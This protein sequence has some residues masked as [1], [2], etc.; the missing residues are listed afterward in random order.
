MGIMQSLR[1]KGRRVD[2]VGAPEKAVVEAT[3]L[4][5]L[6]PDAQGIATYQLHKFPS[7]RDAEIFVDVTLRGRA[8]EGAVLF[9]ALN[10]Q[11]ADHSAEPLV[12][13][14]D[15]DLP[16][17]Y[18][19]SFASIDSCHDFIRHEMTRGLQ[20]HQ[21][22]VYWAVPARVEAD[23]WGRAAVTPS[24]A[25]QPAFAT[26]SAMVTGTA[27]ARPGSEPEMLGSILPFTARKTGVRP[28]D[29]RYLTEADL[30]ETIREMEEFASTFE[31]ERAPVIDFPSASTHIRRAQ[32]SVAMI[33]AWGTFALALDEALDVYVAQQV[34]IR[35]ALNRIMRALVEAALAASL[36]EPASVN[37]HGSGV[38]RGWVNASIALAH[39][40]TVAIRRKL[41][42]RVWMNT[43]WTLEEAAYAHRLETRA[44]AIRGWR[45]ASMACGEAAT[46]SIVRDAALAEEG[47]LPDDTQIAEWL[48]K[49]GV[50]RSTDGERATKNKRA[51][52]WEPRTEPFEGFHSP[53]G[54]F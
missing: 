40:T 18:L 17:V 51:L 31:A 45:F 21:V 5:F 49:Q 15:N 20:L 41:M 9:W 43:A 11:P 16:I 12:L 26:P 28:A 42:Q 6:V 30:A 19:F 8:N 23:F 27:T 7:A 32:K 35:L 48:E 50:H 52:R 13:V 29:R 46:A 4:I 53:P 1:K 47:A 37:G 33:S 54:R 34:R 36:A 39:A 25:P 14:R 38:A 3:P 24:A 10:W 2:V 22:M 44:R